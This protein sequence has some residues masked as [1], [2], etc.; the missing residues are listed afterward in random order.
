MTSRNCQMTRDLSDADQAHLPCSHCSTFRICLAAL[1]MAS[2]SPSL[3]LAHLF[4]K[5]F[6]NFR[7]SSAVF[8]KAST[9]FPKSPDG[10]AGGAPVVA[11]GAPVV[12]G[13]AV[14]GA[15]VVAGGAPV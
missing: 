10:G 5:D 11:G 15:G 7:I 4:C 8:C 12:P 14:V 2:T 9:F 13:A 3:S 6:S 1:W